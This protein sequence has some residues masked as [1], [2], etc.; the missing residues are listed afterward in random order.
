MLYSLIN[1]FIFKKFSSLN[2][3]LLDRFIVLAEKEN[4]EIV[5]VFTKVDLDTDGEILKTFN[6]GTPK[7]ILADGYYSLS[8][9][10][11]A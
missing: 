7:D 9:E 6:T 5:I 8:N 10:G 3:S 1:F 4:L 11:A 2:L